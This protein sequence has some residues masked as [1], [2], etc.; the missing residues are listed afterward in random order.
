[1]GSVLGVW[2]FVIFD[3]VVV[4]GLSI[5][6]LSEVCGTPKGHLQLR[7]TIGFLSRGRGGATL[8]GV[9]Q[10]GRWVSEFSP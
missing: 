2:F 6:N 1:M 7:G 5:F 4:F 8:G 9:G 10:V 3:I